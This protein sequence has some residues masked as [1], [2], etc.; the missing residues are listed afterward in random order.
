MGLQQV[1]A[2]SSVTSVG[3]TAGRT[4]SSGGTTPVLDLATTGV[5]ATTYGSASLIPALTVDAYGR[6]TS[7]TTNAFSAGGMTLLASGSLNGVTTLSLSSI[8]QGY[9]TLVLRAIGMV[10]A[11]ISSQAV[12]INGSTS[13]YQYLYTTLAA[14]PV[15]TYVSGGATQFGVVA[16]TSASANEAS[17]E[18][19][20][21]MYSSV[22]H[23]T[24]VLNGATTGNN[25]TR[26]TNYTGIHTGGTAAITSL[27]FG[28]VAMTGGTYEM[29]GV[30]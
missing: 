17:A 26:F 3:G 14:T 9:K 12:T 28:G 22:G 16:R 27:T 25:S 20:F 8:N 2:V 13:G 23:K 15:V 24:I 19:I 10:T 4:T 5:S 29:Y 1:P 11:S 21:P 30:N 18:I 7:A 6:V